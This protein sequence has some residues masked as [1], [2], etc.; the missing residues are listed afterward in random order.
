MSTQSLPSTIGRVVLSVADL[1]R[2]LDYYQRGIGLKLHKRDNG[3]AYLGVGGDDL[4]ILQ[5]KPGAR[6]ARG[7]AGLYHFALLL[8][9]RRELARTIQHLQASNTPIGGASDHA[10][11]EALYLSDPD[12]HGI[13]IYRDRPRSEWEYPGG[14][15]LL[16]TTPF[17]AEGVMG[18]LDDSEASWTGLH[19]D[20]IMG[21]IHLHVA[22]IPH[23]ELFYNQLLGLDRI[24]RYGAQ[25]SFFSYEGYHHHLGTNTWAGEGAPQALATMARLEWYEL[26]I[27]ETAVFDHICHQLARTSYPHQQSDEGIRLAD[28]AGNQIL[29]SQI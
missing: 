17:D 29:L 6:P 5:E 14:N 24:A 4:L 8:P 27:R 13:E 18:E 15:L 16:N 3:T 10:V 1:S 2:S 25:A 7:V 21:H 9:S 19:P 12:G 22:S 28:P 11:S 23:T 20:T 26:R